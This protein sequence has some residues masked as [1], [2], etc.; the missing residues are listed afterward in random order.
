MILGAV[1][2]V[3]ALSLF[4]FNKQESKRAGEA[5][6]RI[7]PLVIE[8]TENSRDLEQQGIAEI[9]IEGYDY[10]GYL[11]IPELALELPVMKQWSY[12][13]LKIAPCRY[14]GS[15]Q[16]DDLIIVAHNYDSHF[17]SIKWLTG[18]SKVFFTD[19]DGITCQYTVYSVEMLD[20]ND[21]D[22]MVIEDKN[23]DLILLTCT[24]SG[25]SRYIVRCTRS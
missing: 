6:E 14:S 9:Q 2:L 1:L 16:T 24:V 20:P 13:G 15:Q 23:W 18:G 4:L 10:I 21:F 25:K 17:Y 19:M 12:E 3:M 5:S 22:R 7:L 11:S 8:A